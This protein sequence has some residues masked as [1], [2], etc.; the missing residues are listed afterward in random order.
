M[1]YRHEEIKLDFSCIPL[2]VPGSDSQKDQ[3]YFGYFWL[4]SKLSDFLDT[5]SSFE[6][7]IL[8]KIDAK[9][10][11]ILKKFHSLKGIFCSTKEKQSNFVFARLSS[12]YNGCSHL[13]GTEI[14]FCR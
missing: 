7:L 13:G 2:P 3:I 11:N 10:L 8:P 5:V 12:Y 4:L 6:I 1:T 14:W 9:V